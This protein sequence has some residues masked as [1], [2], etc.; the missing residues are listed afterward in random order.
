MPESFLCR[1]FFQVVFFPR[2]SV[3]VCSLQGTEPIVGVLKVAGWW[4]RNLSLTFWTFQTKTREW[5]IW[6][7][8]GKP[9]KLFIL[10]FSTT[11]HFWTSLRSQHRIPLAGRARFLEQNRFL[12]ID[13]IVLKHSQEFK[14]CCSVVLIYTGATRA[15]VGAYFKIITSPKKNL[16]WRQSQSAYVTINMT[17]IASGKWINTI[18]N[19]FLNDLPLS[20]K[21]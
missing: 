18:E 5:S 21:V 2:I 10:T 20:M 12:K 1:V 8:S 7:W 11:S 14:T 16:Q 3:A 17:E 4:N 15:H 13:K 6:L 19:Q 9:I